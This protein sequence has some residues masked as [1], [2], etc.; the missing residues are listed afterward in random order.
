MIELRLTE[1]STSILIQDEFG[2]KKEF[3]LDGFHQMKEEARILLDP[4]VSHMRRVDVSSARSFCRNVEWINNMLTRF[5]LTQLPGHKSDWSD[6]IFK[7][8]EY[9]FT[10]RDRNYSLKSRG[11]VWTVVSQILAIWKESGV[12]P[13]SIYLPPTARVKRDVIHQFRDQLLGQTPMNK[14]TNYKLD[15][16]VGSFELSI[17]DED[18]FDNLSTNLATTR[19]CI[20]SVLLDYWKTI[21]ENYEYGKKLI[22]SVEMES[23]VDECFNYRLMGKQYHPCDYRNGIIGLRNLLA[24]SKYHNNG[25]LLSNKSRA[26]WRKSGGSPTPAQTYIRV[27]SWVTTRAG[28]LGNVLYKHILSNTTLPSNFVTPDRLM[29]RR[30][31]EVRQTFNWMLGNLSPNDVAVICGLLMMLN[32]QFTPSAILNAKVTD[33]NN[34]SYLFSLD[35]VVSFSIEKKRAKQMKTSSLDELSFDI[36]TTILE[37][38]ESRRA[39][40]KLDNQVASNLLF[41]PV[42]IRTNKLILGKDRLSSQLLSGS[43][44]RSVWLGDYYPELEEN[45]LGRGTISPSKIRT[46]EGVLEWFKTGSITAMSKKLGNSHKVAIKHYLPAPL[47]DAWNTRLIRRFQ[48]LWIAVASSH[49]TFALEVTD[50]QTLDELHVFMRDILNLHK[51]GSSPLADELHN[52][53]SNLSHF[54]PN[55][56]NRSGSLHV[57]INESNLTLL[58]TYF[59]S[60]IA[61]GSS[62]D[63]LTLADPETGLS[64][65]YFID[66]AHLLIHKLP[67]HNE[68]SIQSAHFSAYA[69]AERMVGQVRWG[70][71]IVMRGKRCP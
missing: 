29:N 17:S 39:R 35:G 23:L 43:C 34:K 9:V 54:P 42:N 37:M 44:Q 31:A 69:S 36:I 24:L 55:N 32:P 53:F 21:K 28:G 19:N 59:M 11:R 45:G 22:S 63:T 13:F 65:K 2:N 1:N 62:L 7:L 60:A 16:L 33:K 25:D 57:A 5:H 50:F 27:N 41:L 30:N 64:P 71:L 52:N 47:L 70:D 6:F 3:V 14:V 4:I 46:T 15:K 8:H 66:L 40:L 61:L 56:K 49:E 38:S 20:Y 68:P 12:I 18:Y 48:N 58:Y 26:N 51:Q 67:T 10:T